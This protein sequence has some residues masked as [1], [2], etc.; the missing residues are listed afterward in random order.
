MKNQCGD[1]E[2]V[3]E[4]AEL[5]EIHNLTQR[6]EPGDTYPSGECPDCGALCTP[7]EG[8]KLYYVQGKDWDDVEES[9]TDIGKVCELI[10]NF[11]SNEIEAENATVTDSDGTRYLIDV[12]VHLVPIC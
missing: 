5:A 11:A 2:K 4:D 3:W 9:Y 10:E 6:M 8:P 7:Y 1:C 12:T